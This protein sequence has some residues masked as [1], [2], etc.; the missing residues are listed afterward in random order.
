MFYIQL[1]HDHFN[2]RFDIIF[3]RDVFRDDPFRD[4]DIFIFTIV[5]EGS[6]DIK[7]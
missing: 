7:V 1:R 5:V 2:E 6:D 3:F 4:P